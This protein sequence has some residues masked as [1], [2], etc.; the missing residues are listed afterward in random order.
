MGLELIDHLNG[1]V[2]RRARGTH[3]EEECGDS[4]TTYFGQR[5]VFFDIFRGGEGAWGRSGE[6]GGGADG[7]VGGGRRTGAKGG[8][9][10]GGGPEGGGP[11]G[12]GAQY[13]AL[14]SLSPARLVSCAGCFFFPSCRDSSLC[15]RDGVYLT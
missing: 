15:A 1:R 9:Q 8:G 14:F 5:S 11:E 2:R 10:K 6:G 7:G 4:A 13:F 3:A 12:C